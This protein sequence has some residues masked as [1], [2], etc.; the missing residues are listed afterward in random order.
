MWEYFRSMRI[1]R[2]QLLDSDRILLRFVTEQT[3]LTRN[4]LHLQPCLFAIFDWKTTDVCLV[5]IA[6]ETG[7][8]DSGVGG[9]RLAFVG[10]FLVV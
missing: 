7:M 9:I 4:D 5:V 3:L 6:F 1:W 10:V 2:M 8:W